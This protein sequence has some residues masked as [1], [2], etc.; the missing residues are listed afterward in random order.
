MGKEKEEG[1]E[2]QGKMKELLAL[3]AST[4]QT[5]TTSA[6][7]TSSS[8]QSSSSSSSIS[9]SESYTT[10]AMVST[11]LSSDGNTDGISRALTVLNDEIFIH[12]G[13]DGQENLVLPPLSSITSKEQTDSETDHETVTENL[14][15]EGK[16]S[17]DKLL[18]LLKPPIIDD[19]VV[20]TQPIGE[21]SNNLTEDSSD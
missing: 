3:T 6:S 13:T 19:V 20:T 18:E 7:T 15:Q 16:R 1:K 10:K 12:T 9:S 21:S 4:T 11:A 2:K 17:T 5:T 14:W 8:G